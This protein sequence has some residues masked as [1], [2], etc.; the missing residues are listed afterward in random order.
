MAICKACGADKPLMRSGMCSACMRAIPP[1]NTSPVSPPALVERD[2]GV[3]GALKAQS[4]SIE[5]LVA[6]IEADRLERI[7]AASLGADDEDAPAPSEE[8]GAGIDWGSSFVTAACIVIA[9]IGAIFVYG[10]YRLKHAPPVVAPVSG[11]VREY[12]S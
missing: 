3:V 7:S 8:E 5:D 9:L 6:S 11:S 10:V 4:E 2:N 12:I 1:K